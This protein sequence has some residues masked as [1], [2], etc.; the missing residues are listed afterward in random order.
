MKN[1]FLLS[2]VILFFILCCGFV[3]IANPIPVYPNP[4]PVIYGSVDIESVSIQRIILVYIANFFLDILIVYMGLFIIDRSNLLDNKNVLN[5]SKTTFFLAVG[6]ISMIGLISE[7]LL[8][9]WIGGLILALFIIFFSFVFV[10][11]YILLLSRANSY[12]MGFFALIINLLVWIL[13]FTL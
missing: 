2:T 12:R 5:Y 10:S 9:S 11:K 1:H 3:A 13:F 8:G 7:L 4:E 6:I